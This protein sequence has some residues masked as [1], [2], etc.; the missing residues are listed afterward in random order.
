[1]VESDSE[2]LQ[3]L[4]RV[5]PGTPQKISRYSSEYLQVLLRVSQSIPAMFISPQSIS[6]F[7][8][9]LLLHRVSVVAT[10]AM[11]TENPAARM[12]DRAVWGHHT[13]S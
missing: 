2:Y 6:R 10:Q 5:S 13:I 9:P 12:M 3:V 7:P 11:W 1:M 8:Q 4:L